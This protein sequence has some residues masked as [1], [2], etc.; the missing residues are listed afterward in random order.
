MVGHQPLKPLVR[1]NR[2]HTIRQ[3]DD[4]M[5]EPLQRESVQVREI[6]RDMKLGNLA[7]AGATVLGSRQPS[8]KQQKAMFERLAL[9]DD[10]LVG[11]ASASLLHE[12]AERLL[13]TCADWRSYTQPFQMGLNHRGLECRGGSVVPS[14]HQIDERGD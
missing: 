1:N 13:F 12:V 2:D 14:V 3:R 10:L 7:P 8:M 4:V 5:I 6:A 11:R 9:M